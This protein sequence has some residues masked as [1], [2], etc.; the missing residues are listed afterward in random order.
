M[1]PTSAPTR[2]ESGAPDRCAR[3]SNCAAATPVKPSAATST[4][5]AATSRGVRA[6]LAVAGAVR[7]SVHTDATTMKPVNTQ[8][9]R[10][11]YS[12]YPPK[13]RSTDAMAAITATTSRPC[14]SSA[15]RRRARQALQTSPSPTAPR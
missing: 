14:S 5:T 15:L 9:Q 13:I 10:T 11:V 3:A 8:N 12:W 2:A 6:R 1:G 7:Q 4:A